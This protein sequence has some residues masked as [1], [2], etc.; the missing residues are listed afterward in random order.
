[1][2]F[3]MILAS[4]TILLTTSVA[5]QCRHDDSTN[6]KTYETSGQA[7][8]ADGRPLVPPGAGGLLDKSYR[9]VDAY[10]N[11]DAETWN[12]LV[13]GALSE[14]G[15]PGSLSAMKFLGLLSTPRLVSVASVS[16]AGNLTTSHQQPTVEIEVQAENYPVG[17]LVLTF[18]EIDNG[19]CVLVIF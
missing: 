19:R 3:W 12:H 5:A 2:R 1:M 10:Q 4:L 18:V 14:K 7:I 17:N 8:A 16:E 6:K 9:L 11:D 13:C 15:A